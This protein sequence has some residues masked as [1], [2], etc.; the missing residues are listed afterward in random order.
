[1]IIT[2][3]PHGLTPVRLS[4]GDISIHLILVPSQKACLNQHNSMHT[5]GNPIQLSC[6]TTQTAQTATTRTDTRSVTVHSTNYSS[7]CISVQVFGAAGVTETKQIASLFSEP[8]FN[9]RKKHVGALHWI[10][11]YCKKCLKNIKYKQK[12]MELELK[13]NYL[14][15]TLLL[16]VPA[17]QK[18]Q[19]VMMFLGDFLSWKINIPALFTEATAPLTLTTCPAVQSELHSEILLNG[20]PVQLPSDLTMSVRHLSI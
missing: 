9:E 16:S 15:S 18:S 10:I 1:M 12:S 7:A 4:A 19:H 11:K 17:L 14:R 20:A 3:S 6:P 8:L 13:N 2:P 5:L